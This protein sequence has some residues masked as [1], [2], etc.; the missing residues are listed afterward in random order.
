MH[1]HNSVRIFLPSLLIFPI[2]L[3]FSRCI[4]PLLC[5]LFFRSDPISISKNSNAQISLFVTILP[6]YHPMIST[7]NHFIW[8]YITKEGQ[9]KLSSC[10]LNQPH[11]V[12]D[13]TV[14]PPKPILYIIRITISKQLLQ[15]NDERKSEQ[16]KYKKPLSKDLKTC[17]EKWKK[18][19][20]LIKRLENENE[21]KKSMRISRT[22]NFC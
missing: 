10:W 2:F 3:F 9:K 21:W 5:C 8:S 15:L 7:F 22:Q 4:Q 18:N 14:V 6:I 19:W 1:F 20:I 13:R 16:K 11:E 17:K 12:S